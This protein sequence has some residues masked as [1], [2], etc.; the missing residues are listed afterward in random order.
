VFFDMHGARRI[1]MVRLGPGGTALV[2]LLIALVAA[3]ILLLVIGA[4][5]IWIP[6]VALFVTAAVVTGLWRTYFRRRP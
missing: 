2:G 6:L 5:L 4:V 1:R 3:L